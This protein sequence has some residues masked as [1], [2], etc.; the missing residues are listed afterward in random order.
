MAL[1]LLAP[2][3]FPQL[4]LA[5]ELQTTKAV[6]SDLV[7]EIND[8]SAVN[9]TPKPNSLSIETLAQNDPLVIK[10]A[11]FL[12][13]YNS[14]LD[15][16]AAEITKQPHWQLA[17]AVSYVESHMGR[18]CFDNNCSGIGVKP[19]HPSWRKYQ[20][21]LDWFIDLN[22]LL[23]KPVYKDNRNT[24]KKMNGFYVQPGSRNWV[25]GC[26]Q[27]LKELTE[28]KQLAEAERQAHSE[29]LAQNLALAT[30]P[31]SHQN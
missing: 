21:K 13:K 8:V 17:L 25:Y 4:A 15:Q 14:P 18:Y 2:V 27:K 12:Q 10:L 31:L 6:G 22:N 11:K 3:F 29:K 26:E 20:T 1:I 9:Q 30:F 24:C 16:Y 19:G 7:F 28:L 23:D 5:A